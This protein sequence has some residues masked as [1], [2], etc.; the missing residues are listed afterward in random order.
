VSAIRSFI[1]NTFPS[2]P[3]AVDLGCGDFNVGRQIWNATRRYVACDIVS[4]VIDHN[5][6]AYT[7]DDVDFQ[8]LDMISEEP[9]AGDVVF[10]RQVLQH[11]RN[12]QILRFLPKMQYYRWAIVTE[13]VPLKDPFVSN[14]DIPTGKMRLRVN[15]GVELT[16]APFNL[17]AYQAIVLCEAVDG[18]GRI[19]TTA[20][21][22]QETRDDCAEE[23][24]RNDQ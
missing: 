19:R 11:F 7:D 9:P 24:K 12:D 23:G 15:S 18:V 14:R 1:A 6:L 13:Q 17:M 2:P 16:E 5:R 20:Y 22:L 10:V 3:D 21:R 4:G 8:V